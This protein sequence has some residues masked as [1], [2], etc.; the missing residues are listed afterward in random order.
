V[1][2]LATAFGRTDDVTVATESPPR[3]SGSARYDATV[4]TLQRHGSVQ[5]DDL[6]ASLADYVV[7]DVRDRSQFELGHIPGSTHVPIDRLHA[8][9]ELPD[10]RVPVAVLGAGDGD[11]EAA[12]GLLAKHGRDAITISGG[13]QA[14]RAAGRCFVT[15]HP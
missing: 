6:A 11:A 9:W 4:H 14:W 13:A 15:N 10:K 1:A 7:I 3:C 5:P 12:A 8:G 2:N